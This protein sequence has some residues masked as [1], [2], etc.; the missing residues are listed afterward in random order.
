M[1]AGE[2]IECRLHVVLRPPVRPVDCPQSE[3]S[4]KHDPSRPVRHEDKWPRYLLPPSVVH[5][6][7]L[8]ERNRAH[9]PPASA[10]VRKDRTYGTADPDSR[11]FLNS[12]RSSTR[13]PAGTH[14]L[15]ELIDALTAKSSGGGRNG[16]GYRRHA[17]AAPPAGRSRAGQR[18]APTWQEAT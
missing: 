9:D 16:F 4:I 11:P 13:I 5:A 10:G 14:C 3:Q 12:K 2:L 8:G 17:I 1:F 6:H 15:N 18:V 7:T